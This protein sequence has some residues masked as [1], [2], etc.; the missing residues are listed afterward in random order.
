MKTIPP[1]LLLVFAI[2]CSQTSPDRYKSWER[3]NGR[4]GKPAAAPQPAAATE[5]AA[6]AEV[7]KD[8][9]V[10]VEAAPAVSDAAAPAEAAAAVKPAPAPVVEPRVP[11]VPPPEKAVYE[12]N[13][14]AADLNQV[15]Q[16]YAELVNR[17]I[18][19]PANLGAAQFTLKTQTP[20]TK[21]EAIQAFDAVF[22]MNAIA[23]ILVDDKFAKA[24]PA[25][26]ANQEAQARDARS[27]SDL[28]ELGQILTHVAQLK[29]VKP[30]EMVQ[31][32]QPFAK[33]PNSILPIDSSYVLVLRDYTEN[34]KRMLE[35]IERV[36]IIVPA[37]FI[38]EVIPI[39]Y[40]K[41]AD[42]S[43]VLNSLSGGGGGATSFGAR[44]TPSRGPTSGMARPGMMGGPQGAMGAQGAVTPQAPAAGSSYTD[45]LRQIVSRAAAS[46]EMQI[47]GQTKII[48][49]ER[50]NSLLVFATRQDMQMITNIISKLDVV[51]AQVL[52]ETIIMDVS[53]KN[54]WALGLSGVQNP[55]SK[56]NFTGIGGINAASF[57][58]L[59][60]AEGTN[61]L[62]AL[63]GT[64]LRYFGNF[65][66]D[67]YVQ[68]QAAASDGRVNVIQ[69]PRI[70]TSHAT[71][72]S[73]FIGSTVP[74][75]TSTYY[76]GGYGGP[77]SSYQ[78]L[79]VGIGLEVVPYINQDGL[80]V[81]QISETIDEIAGSTDITGVGSVP[82]TTSRTL[83]AEVAV[84]D[85]ETIVLGG[86]IRNS[87]NK[88][89]S[90]VPIL[91]DIPVLGALF[92]SK[93]EN[94]ERMEL[95]VMMRPTV[96]KTP[97]AAALATIEQ[98][99]QMPGISSAEVS[100]ANQEK[101]FTRQERKKTARE[102]SLNRWSRDKAGE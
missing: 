64:G 41:A 36:D 48:A 40:A 11:P 67:I 65:N 55:Q 4:N 37:E 1:L 59:T 27:L 91:R 100:I 76:G 85:G 57:N 10:T 86:F 102:K 78:Q 87:E 21:T 90:G 62:S 18:L 92:S 15:L 13:L 98:K 43:S 52:I 73:I 54:E 97:E 2:S 29:Y 45:R 16:L 28:P 8:A 71:P 44:S 32:L 33:A 5:P 38:S 34:V 53:I 80:V 20:L 39:K 68:L 17:T 70:L 31:V 82:N 9:A 56:G 94:K 101:E 60:K 30:S 88:L 50:A 47:L 72:G 12:Y 51:L 6:V 23:I 74:Y 89:N 69:K 99:K 61:A 81:M 77:S 49:D 26:Q 84:R 7:R 66:D 3:V 46:G 96:L 19:R 24:V 79:R 25:A 95:L 22:A 35:M 93:S 42:I 83:T 58:D 75:V 14:Q 63:I